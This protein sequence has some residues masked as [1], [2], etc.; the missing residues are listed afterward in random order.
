MLTKKQTQKSEK[1][2]STLR[3]IGMGG[4]EAG[5]YMAAIA[6]GDASVS[7][8]AREAGI[9]RTTAYSVIDSL[10]QK[11][12]MRMEMKK[13][14]RCFAAENPDKLVSLLEVRKKNFER[15][16]P[17]FSALYNLKGDTNL[18]KYYEGH[19][20]IKMLYNDLLDSIECGEDYL[21]ISND[22]KWFGLDPEYFQEF[23]EK[24][25]RLNI[26]TR[27]LLKDSEAAR[28]HKKFEKNFSEE[29]RFLPKKVELNTNMVVTSTKL[30]IHQ[31]IP[32]VHVL[33]IETKSIIDLHQQLFEII[34]ASVAEE[35]R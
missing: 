10:T 30:I 12:F 34:W 14:K 32:P 6:L 13:W 26:H 9:K 4:K 7:A 28:H 23:T 1:L 2:L 25:A 16:L 33:V 35:Q 17:N 8:I 21:V 29:I 19:A 27:L 31:L 15:L 22:D 3:D 24:R 5:V 18:V 20:A 11:G